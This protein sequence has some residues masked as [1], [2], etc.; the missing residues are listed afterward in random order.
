[1]VLSR[2]TALDLGVTEDVCHLDFSLYLTAKIS[3]TPSIP[4]CTVRLL[5][6]TKDQKLQK[7]F[8]CIMHKGRRFTFT[9]AAWQISTYWL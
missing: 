5:I 2:D 4:C 7:L 1:M 9:S 8:K 3:K 6:P